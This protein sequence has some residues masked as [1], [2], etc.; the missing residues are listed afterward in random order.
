MLNEKKKEGEG[1]EEKGGTLSKKAAKQAC[2]IR[3]SM[4]CLRRCN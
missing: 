2:A 1:R 4:T 3:N